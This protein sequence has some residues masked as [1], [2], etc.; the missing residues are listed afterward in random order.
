V[1]LE[2][3]E[4]NILCITDEV[5]RGVGAFFSAGCSFFGLP[6][7]PQLSLFV[8]SWPANTFRLEVELFLRLESRYVVDVIDGLGLGM[9]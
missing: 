8:L 9:V 4:F 3:L 7:T 5:V 6:L 2:A 1:L